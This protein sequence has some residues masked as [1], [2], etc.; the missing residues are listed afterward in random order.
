MNTNFMLD[1]MKKATATAFDRAAKTANVE[2]PDL[3][4]YK[5]LKP[6]DFHAIMQQFG[7][8][9]TLDYISAMETKLMK[10]GGNN[11]NS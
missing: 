7:E 2:S 5:K 9:P 8:K 11:A 3:Q 4:L 1:R 10:S 6:E